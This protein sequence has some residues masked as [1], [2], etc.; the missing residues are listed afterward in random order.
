MNEDVKKILDFVTEEK[1]G[2]EKYLTD[3]DNYEFGNAYGSGRWMAFFDVIK[4]IEE[5]ME[6]QNDKI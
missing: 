4:L 1:E 5:L 3:A 2:C 6:A